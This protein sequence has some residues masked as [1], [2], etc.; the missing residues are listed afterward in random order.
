MINDLSKKYYPISVI[1]EAESITANVWRE[2]APQFTRAKSRV[3][4]YI[5]HRGIERMPSFD[6]FES[7]RKFN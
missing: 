7:R 3:Q 6:A 5:N 1:A 2:Q 4:W